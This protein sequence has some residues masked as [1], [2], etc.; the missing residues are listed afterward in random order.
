MCLANQDEAIRLTIGTFK[1]V[2]ILSNI[3]TAMHR[4]CRG[5]RVVDGGCIDPTTG[6]VH[7]DQ[8]SERLCCALLYC[9]YHTTG[10]EMSL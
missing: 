2:P 3:G 8:V 7:S 5:E 6:A 1:D 9:F 10:G 4:Q